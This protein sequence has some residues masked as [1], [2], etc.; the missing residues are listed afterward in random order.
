MIIKAGLKWSAFYSHDII[1]GFFL[2][3]YQTGL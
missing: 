1:F 3:D 2:V